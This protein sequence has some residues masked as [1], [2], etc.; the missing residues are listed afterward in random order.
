MKKPTFTLAAL[1][2]IAGGMIAPSA[3]QNYAV[4]EGGDPVIAALDPLMADAPKRDV[5]GLRIGMSFPEVRAL[6]EAKGFRVEG[7]AQVQSGKGPLRYARLLR[8][9]RNIPANE[10]FFVYFS[11]S[12]KP[13]LVGIYRKVEYREGGAPMFNVLER[14]IGAKYGKPTYD[15]QR[16]RAE[17]IYDWAEDDLPKKCR[18]ARLDMSNLKIGN[19]GHRFDGCYR[20]VVMFIYP[21]VTNPGWPVARTETFLFD[22]NLVEANNA[23]LTVLQNQR[24]TDRADEK[25]E[26][27]RNARPT[28]L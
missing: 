9:G 22:S 21:Q 6:V 20:G 1:F 24:E 10:M 5:M 3:A 7:L 23:A 17:F 16:G 2:A 18:A 11:G 12:S 26:R 15:I 4:P 19:V 25:R 13:R 8:G 27:L 28:E 14:E